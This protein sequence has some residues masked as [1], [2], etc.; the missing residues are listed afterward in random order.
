MTVASTHDLRLMYLVFPFLIWGALR[1]QHLGTAPCALIATTLAARGAAMS[2]G[3]FAGLDLVVRMV[4]LQ[5]FN[6]TA[7]AT[8][9]LL[10]AVIAERNAAREAIERTVAQ[11]ADVVS[12]Y[13]PLLLGNVLPPQPPEKR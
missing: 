8:A 1:F 6:A 7:V 13:Q 3:P 9:L 11:L 2:T 5:A 12:Q 4:T 10:S